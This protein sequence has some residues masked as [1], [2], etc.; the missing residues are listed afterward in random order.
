MYNN[1]RLW[2]V[3]WLA[4]VTV[5]FLAFVLGAT[6]WARLVLWRI[7]FLS[8][9]NQIKLYLVVSGY[10]MLL[11]LGINAKKKKV[12]EQISGK[13]RIY[14]ATKFI[15]FAYIILCSG[16]KFVS[17]KLFLNV[18]LMPP[19]L[20]SQ[21]TFWGNNDFSLQIGKKVQ[22]EKTLGQLYLWNSLFVK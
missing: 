5:W 9:L 17:P 1:Y 10:H 15:I 19:Y 3:G 4:W 20:N 12:V 22:R 8:C 21:L 6:P 11:S 7:Y 2:K 18:E 13:V 16:K 14:L